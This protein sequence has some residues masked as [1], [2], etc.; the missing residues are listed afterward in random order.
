MEYADLHPHP[1]IPNNHLYGSWKST[2]SLISNLHQQQQLIHKVLPTETVCII[3][4]TNP[5]FYTYHIIT[6]G[7]ESICATH[8]HSG[9]VDLVQRSDVVTTFH[10]KRNPADR[11]PRSELVSSAAKTQTCHM[12]TLTTLAALSRAG[13]Q[14]V[15]AVHTHF[16]L[17]ALFGH[18]VRSCRQST[19]KRILQSLKK[20]KTHTHT[21][22]PI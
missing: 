17:L 5:I 12:H 14:K 9:V 19:S 1:N 2:T 7:A 3:L 11:M 22:T 21:H 6:G 13:D 10:L 8:I 20:E 15:K 16:L 18:S 4:P